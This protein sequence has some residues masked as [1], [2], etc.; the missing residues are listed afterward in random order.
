MQPVQAVLPAKPQ[1]IPVREFAFELALCAYL[2]K[3]TDKIVSRQ[4]HTAI[5]GS[6]VMDIVCV[7]PGSGFEERKAITEETI[8]SLAI[9]S[10]V[11]SGKAAYWKK[12][13]DGHPERAREVAEQ[14]IDC[15]FFERERRGGRLYVRQSVRYP[16]WYDSI[17][18]IENKPDLGRPGALETQLLTDI[19]LGLLDKVVVATSSY[20]TGAHQNRIPDPVGIWRFDP[21]TGERTVIREPSQLPVDKAGIEITERASARTAIEVVTA[22]EIERQRR[23]IAERAYGKGWRTYDLPACARIEP[24]DACLPV[25]PWKGR[26]VHPAKE[27]GDSCEGQTPAEPPAVDIDAIRAAR[28]PWEP[29]PP[30]RQRTQ[31]GLDSF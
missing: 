6:R 20:V 4:L 10:N 2:E 31:T 15:G 27:C 19:K 5:H 30:G 12:A 8:P 7:S 26:I 21:E 18:G 16:E 9:E 11:G 23:R 28:S 24:D 1:S 3:Y 25:C 22:N 17:V 14:A 13:F 29:D